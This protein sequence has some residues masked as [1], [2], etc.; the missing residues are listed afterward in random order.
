MTQ[1]EDLNE[2][3]RQDDQNCLLLWTG[4]PELAN[5]Q[6]KGKNVPYSGV[7]HRIKK[8]YLETQTLVYQTWAYLE[9]LYCDKQPG[10]GNVFLKTLIHLRK[11]SGKLCFSITSLCACFSP[12][13]YSFS[14]ACPSAVH[15]LTLLSFPRHQAT[16]E[17]M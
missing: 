5:G 11:E 14:S 17:H 2:Q 1:G 16:E 6:G 15:T 12:G 3:Y 4:H 10:D 13:S 7:L 8:A 9:M